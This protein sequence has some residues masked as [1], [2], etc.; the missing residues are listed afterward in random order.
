VSA[1]D[2]AGLDAALRRATADLQ[3]V[4]HPWRA[5]F[6][7]GGFADELRALAADSAERLLLVSPADLYDRPVADPVD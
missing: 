3:P 5:L 1:R 6:S 2:L 7:R 4:A